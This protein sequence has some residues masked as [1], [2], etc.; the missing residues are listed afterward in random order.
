MGNVRAKRFVARFF[1]CSYN[2][3]LRLSS[4]LFFLFAWIFIAYCVSWARC[5]RSVNCKRLDGIHLHIDFQ[6]FNTHSIGEKRNRNQMNWWDRFDATRL[7]RFFFLV[8]DCNQYNG[9][10]RRCF[11]SVVFLERLYLTQ[12]ESQSNAPSDERM[13]ADWTIEKPKGTTTTTKSF[14]VYWTS[15]EFSHTHTHSSTHFNLPLHKQN[16][17]LVLLFYSYC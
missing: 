13:Y 2:F 3:I 16:G 12:D 1:I 11:F 4:M 5:T 8:L 15:A 9:G 7:R 6:Y 14:I 17:L 10:Y